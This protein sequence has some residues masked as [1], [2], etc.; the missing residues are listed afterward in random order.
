[1]QVAVAGLTI[2]VVALVLEGLAAAVMEGLAA[3]AITE[4]LRLGM[5]AVAA[6]QTTELQAPVRKVLLLFVSQYK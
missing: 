6:V 1:M 4:A 5:E 2:M 3:V